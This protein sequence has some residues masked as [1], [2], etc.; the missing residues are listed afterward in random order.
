MS[1]TANRSKSAHVRQRGGYRDGFSHPARFEM[2]EQRL[3]LNVAPGT[4]EF[5]FQSPAT[6][7]VMEQGLFSLPGAASPTNGTNP[8]N[9]ALVD[10]TGTQIPDTHVT[11]PATFDALGFA[12]PSFIPNGR[13]AL[14]GW[15][16]PPEI[17]AMNTAQVAS[18][19]YGIRN[20][21]IGS[22]TG[23]RHSSG[24]LMGRGYPTV[25]AVTE[26][27]TAM[28]DLLG[29]PLMDSLALGQEESDSGSLKLRRQSTEPGANPANLQTDG[30]PD[31]TSVR[32]MELADEQAT[33]LTA[34]Q[35]SAAPLLDSAAV[36][37]T[38]ASIESGTKT[39]IAPVLE[40]AT[41]ETTEQ[42]SSAG[43]AAHALA[44]SIAVGAIVAAKEPD[45]QSSLSLGIR[46]R[47]N[48]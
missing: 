47:N 23:L 31:E 36:D 40:L 48:S 17:L 19:P 30:Q 27:R 2:L 22:N 35:L 21:E 25:R 15:Y 13:P 5:G 18:T 8:A 34:A 10:A 33:E 26:T 16:L 12:N 45:A 28:N 29:E 46:R 11:G 39:A 7:V 41:A 6:G 4:T 37:Q 3:T 32:M 44:A 38:M 20:F 42:R 43:N 1:A 14:P 9:Y 24:V